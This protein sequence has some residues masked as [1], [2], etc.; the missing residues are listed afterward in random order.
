[1]LSITVEQ[2]DYQTLTKS[3]M[4]IFN[5]QKFAQFLNTTQTGFAHSSSELN[6]VFL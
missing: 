4:D 6:L 2:Y 3:Y 1:M 5:S